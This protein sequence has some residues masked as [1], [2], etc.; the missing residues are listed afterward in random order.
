M[1]RNAMTRNV[2][3]STKHLTAQDR[4]DDAYEIHTYANYLLCNQHLYA[5]RLP[6]VRVVW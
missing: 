2:P 5:A 3:D 4:E 1:T 6:K